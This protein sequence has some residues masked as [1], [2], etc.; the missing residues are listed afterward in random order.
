MYADPSAERGR[1]QGIADPSEEATELVAAIPSAAN[2]GRLIELSTGRAFPVPPGGLTVGRGGGCNIVIEGKGVSRQH[3]VI[4]PDGPTFTISDESSN[5][6]YVN[7][8]RIQGRGVLAQDDVIRIGTH[9]FRLEVDSALPDAGAVPPSATELL[10]GVPDRGPKGRDSRRPAAASPVAGGPPPQPLALLEVTRGL[11]ARKLFRVERAACAIG[12]SEQNDVRL[13]DNSVSALHAT[14]VLKRGS[15]YIVDLQSANG[16]Y[17]EGYRVAGERAVPDGATLRVGD[18]SMKFRMLSRATDKSNATAPPG[19]M[20]RR[21]A[22][23]WQP[24]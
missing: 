10:A 5:G 13:T 19:G 1:G 20:L 21:L 8:T 23:F 22:R 14:L 2:S 12:R 4:R 3:A 9:E 16:T 17:V 24:E 7:G 6:T 15:W 18:V 11:Q